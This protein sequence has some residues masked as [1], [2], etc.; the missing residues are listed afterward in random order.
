VSTGNKKQDWGSA[1][2]TVKQPARV[3][4]VR[5]D[6]DAVRASGTLTGSA[7]LAGRLDGLTLVTELWDQMGRLLSQESAPVDGRSA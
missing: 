6:G 4:K 7:R 5:L 3:V 2:Y 1:S